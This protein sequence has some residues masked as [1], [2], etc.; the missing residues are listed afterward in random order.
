MQGEPVQTPSGVV[1]TMAG[2]GVQLIASQFA[3]STPR[4]SVVAPGEVDTAEMRALEELTRPGPFLTRTHQL[5]RFL[6]IRIDGKLA[7]MAGERMQPEGLTEVSAV[8]T[9]P[10]HVGK[11]N[12]ATLT[13]AV[14]DRTLW[15]KT[16]PSCMRG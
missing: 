2:A 3:G 14:A 1:A 10:D 15:R 11:G 7:A 13:L 16:R 6:G 12:G 8:C 4:I 5:G 9:D